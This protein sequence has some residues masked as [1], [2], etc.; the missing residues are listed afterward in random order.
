MTRG[1]CHGR[2]QALDERGGDF[3]VPAARRV[4]VCQFELPVAQVVSRPAL[5][6]RTLGAS[7][8]QHLLVDRRAAGHLVSA[9]PVVVHRV[10]KSI[11]SHEI[12][13]SSALHAAGDSH[14]AWLR[15]RRRKW[16]LWNCGFSSATLLHCRAGYGRH[17]RSNALHRTARRDHRYVDKACSQVEPTVGFGWGAETSCRRGGQSG[18]WLNSGSAAEAVDR[19]LSQ[20]VSGLA[21]PTFVLTSS[22]SASYRYAS[23]DRERLRGRRSCAIRLGSGRRGRAFPAGT[24]R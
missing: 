3:C 5:M 12:G 6:C 17:R 20:L 8:D 9:A 24:K 23:I 19:L 16:P 2:C 18:R 21:V 14:V 13:G 22:R 10:R 7:A 1:C 15:G 4:L 11:G